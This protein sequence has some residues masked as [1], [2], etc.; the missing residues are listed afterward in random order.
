MSASKSELLRAPLGKSAIRFFLIAASAGTQQ[1][2][3]DEL[4]LALYQ[5]T[6]NP[7][8]FWDSL[9]Y[10]IAVFVVG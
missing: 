3:A 4:E 1:N 7:L 2:L 8:V 6:V 5:D 9:I 10:K